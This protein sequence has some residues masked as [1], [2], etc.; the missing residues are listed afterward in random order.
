[1]S[2]L[3]TRLNLALTRLRVIEEAL[4]GTHMWCVRLAGVGNGLVIPVEV[5]SGED[6]ILF[7][8]EIPANAPHLMIELLMDG[9]VVQ[10]MGHLNSAQT[11]VMVWWLTVESPLAVE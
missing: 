3:E 10:T 1:M 11:C 9:E 2:S 4:H 5:Q 7:L 6:G 8:A